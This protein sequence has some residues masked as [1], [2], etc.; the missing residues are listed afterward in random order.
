V[1]VTMQ[2]SPRV[3]PAQARRSS[4]VERIRTTYGFDDVSLAPGVETVE[5]SD[6]DTSVAFAGMRLAVPILAAAM[7]AVVDVRFAGELARLGGVAVLNLEGVQ[8]RYDE[9]DVVLARIAGAPDDQVHALLAEAYQAPVQDDLVV[10]RVEELHVGR[11]AGRGRL[12]PRGGPP[13]GRCARSTAPT[14]PRPVPWCRPHATSR[15]ATTRS[16]SMRSRDCLA[17]PVAV[18]TPPRM[19]RRTS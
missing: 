2:E 12:D 14:F 17:Y 3:G 13:F 8:T 15:P 16:S 9:P 4:R 19:T 10:R 11:V 7:D 5:P 18:G 6:V 1:T